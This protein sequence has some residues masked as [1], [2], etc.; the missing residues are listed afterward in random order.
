MAKN[1]RG[2]A[3]GK[4]RENQSYTIHGRGKI[5][6]EQAVK[7]VKENKHPNHHVIIVNGVEYIRANNDSSQD[8]NI[9]KK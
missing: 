3:D 7:E 8:N 4:N 1:I 2:N 5:S 6:R 9:D